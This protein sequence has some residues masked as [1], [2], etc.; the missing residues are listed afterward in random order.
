MFVARHSASLLGSG[1]VRLGHILIVY[2]SA[3]NTRKE[4]KHPWP[5]VVRLQFGS[6]V[7]RPFVCCTSPC[8]RRPNVRGVN[9]CNG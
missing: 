1:C 2:V 7:A 6:T 8:G 4:K 5:L 3:Q 9:D